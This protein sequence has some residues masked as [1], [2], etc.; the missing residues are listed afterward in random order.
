VVIK[1]GQLDTSSH[2]ASAAAGVSDPRDVRLIRLVCTPRQELESCTLA[3]RQPMVVKS[4]SCQIRLLEHIVQI[5]NCANLFRY[6]SG[7][8]LD[9]F[10]QRLAEACD[11]IDV[12]LARDRPRGGDVHDAPL[13]I[14][15]TKS[16]ALG[17]AYAR[18][19]ASQ[20]AVGTRHRAHVYRAL[21]HF[22]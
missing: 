12:N 4:P 2:R 18:V 15:F 19:P 5:R 8:A 13:H 14:S 3:A 7:D 6:T 17:A 11:L 1:V 21:I 10:N 20:R 16:C 22:G 9:M